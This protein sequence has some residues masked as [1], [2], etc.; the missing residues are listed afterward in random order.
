MSKR[1][2]DDASDDAL[3]ADD[4]SA[5]KRNKTHAEVP[6]TQV[7]DD[8]NPFWSISTLGTRR[9]TV[10]RYR[11]STFVQIR[12]Y[13]DAGSELKPGKKVSS[14]TNLCELNTSTRCSDF[15]YC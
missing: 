2:H 6:K 5:S 10:S 14:S 15:L 9:V 3:S 8:N 12:E 7:D 13:Y 11:G 4:V 1:K